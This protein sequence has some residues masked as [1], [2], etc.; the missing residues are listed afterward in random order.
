MTDSAVLLFLTRKHRHETLHSVD[1]VLSAPSGLPRRHRE[2]WGCVAA[3]CNK[4]SGLSSLRRPLSTTSVVDRLSSPLLRD[5]SELVLLAGTVACLAP[6]T[7][8][9]RDVSCCWSACNATMA[10]TVHACL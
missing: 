3:S 9:W 8:W 10:V 5:A 1:D 6:M 4:L 2:R 7:I